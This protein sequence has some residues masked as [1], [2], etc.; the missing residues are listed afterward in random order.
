MSLVKNQIKR[1][2]ISHD[3]I[4]KSM[5]KISNQSMLQ[6]KWGTTRSL[7]YAE[8]VE[9]RKVETMSFRVSKHSLYVPF[10]L[11]LVSLQRSVNTSAQYLSELCDT[12]SGFIE[13]IRQINQ[14]IPHC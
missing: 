8:V 13:K 11:S 10:T 1:T 4:A 7:I 14:E 9:K 3:V 6:E 2:T 5:E 12:K